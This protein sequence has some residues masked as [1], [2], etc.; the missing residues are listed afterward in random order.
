MSKHI[1][2][3]KDSNTEFSVKLHIKTKAM[4]Y[5]C[6]SRKCDSW[7]AEKV[8]IA[9]FE[10]VVL[11]NK[12]TELLS[13]CRHGNKLIIANIKWAINFCCGQIKNYFILRISVELR[14]CQSIFWLILKQ[15]EN[16]LNA[17]LRV[18]TNYY[19]HQVNLNDV[20]FLIFLM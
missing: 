4:S 11:L 14:H 17:E 2:W 5:K 10:G 12:R 18:T 7:L 3:L 8:A 9:Q 16:W 13:K 1:W 19:D 15:F 20:Q 6:G